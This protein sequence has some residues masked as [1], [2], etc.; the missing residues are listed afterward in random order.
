MR[1]EGAQPW[2][3]VTRVYG[4]SYKSEKENFWR[5][6]NTYFTPLSI[7]CLYGGDFNE[8]IWDSEKS[9]ETNVLYNRAQYLEEFMNSSDLLYLDFNGPTFTSRGMR[10]RTLWMSV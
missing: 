9:G 7:P 10:N 2:V 5:W 6:M 4:T 3:R 8:F 1:E